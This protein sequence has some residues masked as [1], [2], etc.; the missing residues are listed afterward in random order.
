MKRRRLRKKRGEKAENVDCKEQNIK[1]YDKRRKQ[2]SRLKTRSVITRANKSSEL[3]NLI[4]KIIPYEV[5]RQ[6][7]LF[8][9]FAYK[10]I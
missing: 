5:S 1:V 10:K 4:W 3:S 9:F 6:P 8:F 2:L 7:F